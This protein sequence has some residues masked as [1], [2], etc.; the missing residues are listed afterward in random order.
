MK[1]TSFIVSMAMMA[2]YAFAINNASQ[3]LGDPEADSLAE[4]VAQN[5]ALMEE[6]YLDQYQEDLT[7]PSSV[8]SPAEAT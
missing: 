7:Q 5:D 3:L 8:E 1:K 2:S 4:Q 6:Q